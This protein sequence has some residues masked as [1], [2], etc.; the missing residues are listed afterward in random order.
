MKLLTDIRFLKGSARYR[1]IAFR[2]NDRFQAV[3]FNLGDTNDQ[4]ARSLYL[5][6]QNIQNDVNLIQP[7]NITNP[8]Y[9][10]KIEPDRYEDTSVS[11]TKNGNMW[12]SF[13]GSKEELLEVARKIQEYF[14]NEN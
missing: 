10:I 6:G 3:K 14:K 12:N 2:F 8:K 5:L 1:E 9:K 4:V 13:T 11:I 7:T